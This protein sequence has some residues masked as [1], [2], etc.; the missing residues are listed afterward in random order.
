MYVFMVLRTLLRA[1]PLTTVGSFSLFDLVFLKYGPD[2]VH[3]E[4]MALAQNT[5]VLREAMLLCFEPR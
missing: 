4:Y 3:Y 5:F 2:I 1:A